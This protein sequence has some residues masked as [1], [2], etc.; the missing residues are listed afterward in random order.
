MIC[1]SYYNDISIIN[2]EVYN[3]YFAT[4]RKEIPYRDAKIFNII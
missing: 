3:Q 1:S 2:K 4:Y